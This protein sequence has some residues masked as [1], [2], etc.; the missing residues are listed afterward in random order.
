MRILYASSEVAPWVKTGGLGDVSSALPKAL[1]QN[2]SDV[3]V[4]VPY[5]NAFKAAFADAP[6]VAAIDSIGHMP[7]SCVREVTL[8]DGVTLYMLD[9]S[10]LYERPG[11]PYL[12][13]D[14]HDWPDN[15]IRFGLLSYAAALLA[16]ERTP[17]AWKAQILHCNDWQTALAPVYLRYCFDAADVKVKTVITVHNLAFQ[18]LFGHSMLT[19]LG[20]AESSWH[21]EGVEF[22]GKLSFL[23]AGLQMAD[24]I[25]TVSPSYAREILTP[26]E[27]MGLDGL[28][29]H[30]SDSLFGIINGID[31]TQWN[32]AS[33]PFILQKYD[34]D[35]LAAKKANKSALQK[36]LGLDQSFE[37]PLLGVVSR[38]TEQKGLDLLLPIASAMAELPIQLAVLG[39]GE[40]TLEAGFLKLAQR[41]PGQFGIR[42]GYDEGLAH[43]IEAGADLFVMPSRFEP[44]GLN[45][46][47]SMHYG[48]PPIV[49]STG[50]LADTVIDA[51]DEI[52]G[53]GFVFGEA[54]PVA[55]LNAIGRAVKVWQ[56]KARFQTLQRQGMLTDWSWKRPAHSMQKIYQNLLDQQ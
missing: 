53:T 45:Q 17:L 2:G 43:R 10:S 3:R 34:A 18:G 46:L 38:L 14:G 4:I 19:M 7:Q 22:H 26:Q 21:M 15:A 37:G 6:V 32:P 42:I 9:C 54:S 40:I 35:S 48:T 30:R 5:Y 41:Y 12:G 51:S 56:N 1:H 55:L 13:V 36:E 52:N 16:S 29:R 39:A 23:K 50:G 25:T 31:E 20:L 11:S 24:A 28:L 27:G 33:D 44:C 47:Y 8:S 49:R